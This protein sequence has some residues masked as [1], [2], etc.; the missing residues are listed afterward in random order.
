M[1][2]VVTDIRPTTD[3]RTPLR[4]YACP[5]CG[6]YLFSTEDGKSGPIRQNCRGCRRW[7]ILDLS[8]GKETKAA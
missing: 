4:E 5:R 7:L 6:R 1:S 8:T 2:A 3:R